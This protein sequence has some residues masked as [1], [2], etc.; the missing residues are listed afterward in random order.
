MDF[1]IIANANCKTCKIRLLNVEYAILTVYYYQIAKT[2][3]LYKSTDVPL[4]ILL[5]I[6]PIE[7]GC[8]ISIDV[9]LYCW[10]W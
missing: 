3:A 6:G 7:T 5:T 10:F 2:K 1:I 4:G 8:Q 9:Y